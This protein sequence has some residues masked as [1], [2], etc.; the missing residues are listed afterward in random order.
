MTTLFSAIPSSHDGYQSLS[1]HEI[2]TSCQFYQ[3]KTPSGSAY[4][5][6]G[7]ATLPPRKTTVC[8][9]SSNSLGSTVISLS[10]KDGRNGLLVWSSLNSKPTPSQKLIPP[11]RP[12]V[13]ALSSSGAYLA[14][15]SA[16]GAVSMW[17][18]STGILLAS[19]DAHYKAITCIAFSGDDASIITAS[20]DAICCVW[21]I[22]MKA[23]KDFFFSSSHQLIEKALDC[24][25]CME[26]YSTF[27]D[28]TLPISD[29]Q[30][31]PGL[32]PD[33][34]IFTASLDRTV[35]IWS[36]LF[37]TSPLL[38]TFTV[39]G[40][41][42]YLAVDPLERFIFVSYATNN[43]DRDQTR[44]SKASGHP[45]ASP[46]SAS[47]VRLISLF[48]RPK[49][50]LDQGGI[51]LVHSSPGTV[52]NAISPLG[53]DFV[54]K[55]SSSTQ[56][57]AL[58][59]PSLSLASPILLCGLSNGTILHL[60]IPS[61]QP[62]GQTTP[63]SCIK[64]SYSPITCINTFARPQDLLQTRSILGSDSILSSG[65]SSLSN[66]I[67]IPRPIG[68]L[69]RV[70]GVSGEAS[71]L[72]GTD[73]LNEPRDIRTRAATLKIGSGF[74]IYHDETNLD[75]FFSSSKTIRTKFGAS[76]MGKTSP[77]MFLSNGINP[78]ISAQ[79]PA[80]AC[81]KNNVEELRKETSELKLKLEEA[82]A[83][84]EALW[85]GLVKGTLQFKKPKSIEE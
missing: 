5:V 46:D 52:H 84:N 69:A 63:H 16:D 83:F 67:V 75:G 70:V 60:S 17:E 19:F 57:T 81:D 1:F 9:P 49:H 62:L 78:I 58:H 51:S 39:P 23:G 4:V 61:L 34:R 12:T 40:P 18:L 76:G 64:G 71:R 6:A 48:S 24:E 22:P 21:S 47:T 42:H 31:T 29:V 10:G 59:L 2:S 15:G 33:I 73:A 32:F 3:L 66:P 53:E 7:N 8:L 37:A 45:G 74:S 82:L 30:I 38:S 72:N 79:A 85:T 26:P 25:L 28:H 41:A 77:R 56:I 55:S 14:T 13:V 11:G 50:S 80:F 65:S 35:K 43:S 44:N 36:P 20:D 27:S 68:A 54:Y